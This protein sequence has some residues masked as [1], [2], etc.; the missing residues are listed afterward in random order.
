VVLAPGSLAVPR[1]V[2]TASML[3]CWPASALVGIGAGRLGADELPGSPADFRACGARCRWPQPARWRSG[4]G[5]L[6]T[7]WLQ[8]RR[9][10][11]L[12]D[13]P[14]PANLPDSISRSRRQAPLEADRRA[15][16]VASFG[17]A[18]GLRQRGASADGRRW[19]LL[20][21]GGPPLP[22]PELGDVLAGYWR[23]TGAAA[24]LR[25]GRGPDWAAAALE[26]AQAGLAVLQGAGEGAATPR[27]LPS[28]W[29]DVLGR[30]A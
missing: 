19:Q 23:R 17:V 26:H 6:G 7:T 28:S 22:A 12:A 14:L 4:G 27:R 5:R 15:R 18:Q 2:L 8:Q 1:A 29:T 9:G 20:A 16:G 30:V 11:N 24:G 25:R 21:A 3:F 10:P 13:P